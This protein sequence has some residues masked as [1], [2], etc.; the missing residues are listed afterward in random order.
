MRRVNLRRL[1][2]LALRMIGVALIVLA[3]ARPT[4]KGRLATLFPDDGART[5]CILLDRSYSM[6]FDQES[7]TLFDEAKSR[8]IEILGSLDGEDE[9]AVILF[10]SSQDLLYAGRMNGPLIDELLDETAPSWGT[11]DLAG[12]LSAG[13]GYLEGAGGV[14]RELF[15]VSDFQRSSLDGGAGRAEKS[16][17]KIAAESGKRGAMRCFL[18][19]VKAESRAN[20]SIERVSVPRTVLHRGEAAGIEILMRSSGLESIERFPLELYLDGRLVI[21]REVVVEPDR[22]AAETF[23]LPT[24]R[25]GWVLGEARKGADRLRADD[26]RYFSLRISERVKTLLVAED[27]AF[28]LEQALKPEG[29]E[30]DIEL[31]AR[32]YRELTSGDIA[33]ADVVVLGP[34][35]GP[36]AQDL[37]LLERSVESGARAIVFVLPELVEAVAELSGYPLSITFPD[38]EGG[39]MR[40]GDVKGESGVL[41]PFGSD[42][43]EGMRKLRFVKRATVKGVPYA[44]GII[45]FSDGAPFIWEEER[46]E[47]DYIF[48][49]SDPRPGSGELVLS[50][51][52]LPLVQQAALAVA[53][54]AGREE[55][56]VV[57]E[58]VRFGGLEPGA[59][60]IGMPPRSPGMDRIEIMVQ[61]SGADSDD[62]GHGNVAAPM[63]ENPGF[64]TLETVTDTLDVIAA[65]VSGGAE[66]DLTRATEEEVADSLGLE[67]WVAVREGRPLEEEAEY[68][69]EGREMSFGLILAAALT[70]LAESI[71]SQAGF[72]GKSDVG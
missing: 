13:I 1:L 26:V 72:E 36:R 39:F 60:R 40:I 51:Y 70:L 33:G 59:I 44:S 48:I 41:A 65:N 32:S 66:S 67:H 63:A 2:L 43:I 6:R 20:I 69:R 31:V 50:P 45:F 19:P 57:G 55:G 23:V 14:Q 37:E 47:G 3:F 29:A 58:P 15:I 22:Y 17:M 7:G 30:G 10:D 21:E 38:L 9:V 54:R 24:F 56:I 46:G 28:Y 4:V 49:V 53:D 61:H 5:A 71:L 68:A 42:D 12:A 16:E 62:G 27:D 18:V 11:T 8:V 52:F 64:V 35:G 25:T 34:G